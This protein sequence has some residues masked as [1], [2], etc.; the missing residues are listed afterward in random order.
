MVN[1]ILF[2]LTETS[3]DPAISVSLPE[4]DLGAA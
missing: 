1:P 2:F 4:T 3:L